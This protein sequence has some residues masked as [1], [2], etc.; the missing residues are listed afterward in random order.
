[1]ELNHACTLRRDF[2]KMRTGPYPRAG[3]F[4]FDSFRRFV[5]S[6]CWGDSG[7]LRMGDWR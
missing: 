2:Y 4:Y 6:L 5:R 1:M 3:L 7:D